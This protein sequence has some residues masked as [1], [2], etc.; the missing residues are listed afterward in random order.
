MVSPAV[1]DDEGEEGG[2]EALRDRPSEDELK[3]DDMERSCGVNQQDDSHYT[4]VAEVSHRNTVSLWSTA[5]GDALHEP[6]DEGRG[7]DD[8]VG[9]GQAL[10]SG[11]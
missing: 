8:A 10:G 5:G 2:G 9:R 1:E 11:P 6:V 3:R 4:A 7:L